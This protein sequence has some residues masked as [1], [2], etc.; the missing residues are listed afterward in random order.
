MERGEGVP[1]R[2]RSTPVSGKKNAF[3]GQDHIIT[4]YVTHFTRKQVNS[5]Y[6]M[7]N[8]DYGIYAIVLKSSII[9]D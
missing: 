1:F 9:S 4:D 3:W 8:I 2:S 6:L 5:D 7:V